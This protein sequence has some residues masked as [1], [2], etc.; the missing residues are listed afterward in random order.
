M[1]EIIGRGDYVKG[2]LDEI[3]NILLCIFVK[4]NIFLPSL[5]KKLYSCV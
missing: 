1:Q 5:Q 3:F 2:N 4:D